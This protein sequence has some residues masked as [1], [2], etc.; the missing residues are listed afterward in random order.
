MSKGKLRDQKPPERQT[1]SKLRDKVLP[2]R[3]RAGAGKLRGGITTLQGQISMCVPTT[4]LCR[5][6]LGEGAPM[7]GCMKARGEGKAASQ[8]SPP[9]NTRGIN[10]RGMHTEGR[11]ATM[12][13]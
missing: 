11:G 10:R 3:G 4:T 6:P 5:S 8:P 1:S 7:I 13:G 2:G 12:E 9:N